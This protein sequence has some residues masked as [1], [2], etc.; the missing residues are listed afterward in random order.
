[1]PAMT[2]SRSIFCALLAALSLSLAADAAAQRVT[3][4]PEN[5]PAPLGKTERYGKCMRL[6]RVDPNNGFEEA[7]RWS[8]AGGGDA[9]KH[10]AAVALVHLKQFGEAAK[11]LGELAR[12][13]PKKTPN[14]VRA[15]LLGQSGQAWMR[16]RKPD[17]AYSAQTAAIALD[18]TNSALYVDRALTLAAL[19]RYPDAIK[20]LNKALEYDPQSADA[21]AMRA[22][23][24]RFAGDMAAARQDVV[25]ALAIEPIHPGGLLESGILLRL[26]GDKEGARQDWLTLI[27]RHDGTPAAETAKKNLEKLDLKAK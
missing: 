27:E 18:P 23:A 19:N 2:R 13:M 10:C 26:A 1:M 6:A 3:P 12:S 14:R 9:A 20:D 21:Y 5:G 22:S 4:P 17:A 16:A 24:H 25:R 7:L 8:D 11:R 15:E